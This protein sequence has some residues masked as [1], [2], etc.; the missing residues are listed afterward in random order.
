MIEPKLK[1]FIVTVDWGDEFPA[2][3]FFQA[4]SWEDLQHSDCY[5]AVMSA[6]PPG[7]EMTVYPDVANVIYEEKLAAA[8]QFQK[9]IEKRNSRRMKAFEAAILKR[10]KA[11]EKLIVADW[12]SGEMLFFKNPMAK[13]KTP[14]HR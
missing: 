8:K 14:R 4:E 9:Y 2:Y 7:F 1:N 11:G 6:Y 5:I 10:E 13:H 12:N 3:H